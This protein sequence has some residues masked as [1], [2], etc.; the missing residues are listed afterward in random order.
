[1]PANPYAGEVSIQI[2]GRECILL[3]DYGALARMRTAF[4]ERYTMAVN[5]ALGTGDVEAIVQIASIA[6]QAR[7]AMTPEEVSAARPPIVP[8][9]EALAR[10]FAYAWWGPT[11]LPPQDEQGKA[12][13]RKLRATLATLLRWGSRRRSAAA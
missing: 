1:M 13:G 8:L 10:A 6:L 5:A 11:G 2:G 4:G 7:N 9:V 3:F 12:R